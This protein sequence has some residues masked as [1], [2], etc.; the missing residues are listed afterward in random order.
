MSI[1]PTVSW[2][3]DKGGFYP[4]HCGRCDR[5]IGSVDTLAG[6]A[7]AIKKMVTLHYC[8]ARNVHIIDRAKLIQAQREANKRNFKKAN[9]LLKKAY[10]S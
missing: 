2:L 7:E 10:T 3:P 9:E 8:T 5:V 4:V 1:K 6:R